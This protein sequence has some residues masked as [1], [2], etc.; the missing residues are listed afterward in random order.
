MASYAV[1]TDILPRVLHSR[2]LLYLFRVGS[3]AC[4]VACYNVATVDHTHACY[5]VTT[6]HYMYYVVISLQSFILLEILNMFWA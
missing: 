6:V 4:V 2:T 1:S 5:Y 3:K